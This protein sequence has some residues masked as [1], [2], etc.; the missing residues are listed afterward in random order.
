MTNDF[1][2]FKI[3]LTVSTNKSPF[4]WKKSAIGR[5]WYPFLKVIQRPLMAESA[6]QQCSIKAVFDG[7]NETTLCTLSI[8][9][10]V[11]V[12]VNRICLFV[13]SLTK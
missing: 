8:E 11:V 7:L 4:N 2:L 5:P 6:V 10:R 3:F 1:I 12:P 9:T 13:H